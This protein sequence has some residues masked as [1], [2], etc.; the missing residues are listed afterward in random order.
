M[1][2]VFKDKT[3]LEGIDIALTNQL[4][5]PGWALRPALE[6]ALKDSKA[7]FQ[8]NHELAIVFEDCKAIAL[9]FRNPDGFGDVYGWLQSV[10]I[11]A[12]CDES[13]RQR[14][15]ASQC[16]QAIK[17]PLDKASTGTASS[18]FFWGK[19]EV[20]VSAK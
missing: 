5:V 16:V 12:F 15:F 1:I 17:Q 3:L 13:Y 9:A 10:Q 6:T 11:M 19:H 2:R 20:P 14:G 7:G 18:H 4:Y 8:C